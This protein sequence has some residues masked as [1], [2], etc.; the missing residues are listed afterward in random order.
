MSKKK[1]PSLLWRKGATLL[2]WMGPGMVTGA[3]DDDPSGIATY[4]QAGA[5][6][7]HPILWTMVFTWPLMS[8]IQMICG[9][10]GRV[11][12]RGVAANMRKF[13][14]RR[15]ALPM[16]LLLLISNVFNLGAD[17]GAMGS[18]A[19]LIFGGSAH[20]FAV[21]FTIISVVLQ[22][23]VPYR[24]YSNVL[25][26]LTFVLLAY[27]GVI[28]FVHVQWGDVLRA[29]LIPTMVWDK[30]YMATF[31]A[32]L[33][34]TIS[35]YLFF[36]QSSQV[37]ED[38]RTHKEQNALLEYPEEAPAALRWIRRDTLLG[39]GFSNIIAYS[40]ILVTA[41]TLHAHG[42]TQIDTASQAAEALRPLAG[43]YCFLLFSLGIIGTGLLAVP[44]LAGSAAFAV[45][46]A[47]Q[48]PT[49]LEDKPSHAKRF[50]GVLIFAT[51]LGMLLIYVGL[52]PIR[53]LFWSAVINGIIS[54]PI[55]VVIML[56]ASRQ[57]IMGKFTISRV[58][59]WLGW[60][61]TGVMLVAVILFFVTL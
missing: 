7:G 36:W 47:L 22:V 32:L 15:V 8:A 58:W 17:I 13:Y 59:R 14:G 27:I 1:R 28:F 38:I 16:V 55:M 56:M 57:T 3:A 29:T 49:S 48:F 40:I 44:V 4:S 35:P 25:K 54:A 30:S 20:I 52:N 31:V 50:Y 5:Q 24:K 12:G 34:T 41:T 21:S 9:Q 61:A 19:V 39:M 43:P 42:V 33:G 26:W 10:I 46:E 2:Q 45:G 53:A 51:L 37:V 18:A 11:T 23:F 6:L 60:A